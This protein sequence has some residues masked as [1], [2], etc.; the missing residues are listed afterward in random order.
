MDSK[1][2]LQPL[3]DHL[4]HNGGL[5]LAQA[6]KLVE[7]VIAYLHETP[8]DFVRRRHA[9]IKRETGL[10]NMQIFARIESELAKRVFSAPALSQRQIR[11]II[12]G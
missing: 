6:Q 12:Y 1:S 7:E 9:E 10:A 8:E 2:D 3:I 5:S 4:R 11:R